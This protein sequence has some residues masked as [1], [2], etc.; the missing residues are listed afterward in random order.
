MLIWRPLVLCYWSWSPASWAHRLYSLFF[1][2]SVFFFCYTCY[3]IQDT[4]TL[5][6]LDLFVVDDACFYY[7]LFVT[8][9]AARGS[10]LLISHYAHSILFVKAPDYNCFIFLQRLI[11]NN[12]EKYYSILLH[13]FYT[14]LLF[15][16]C[17]I[18]LK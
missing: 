18:N 7:Y 5:V 12:K 9:S 6:I 17:N 11:N 13:S 3:C 2:S 15:I 10:T 4:L 14:S 8:S 16:Y 1:F